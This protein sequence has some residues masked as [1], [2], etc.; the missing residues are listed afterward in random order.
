[1]ICPVCKKSYVSKHSCRIRNCPTCNYVGDV[2]KHKCPTKTV[3][4]ALQVK[5][6][7]WVEQ[8]TAS[9]CT[10][11]ER[12]YPYHKLKSVNWEDQE[13]TIC[14]YCLKHNHH[15]IEHVNNLKALLTRFAS[16]LLCMNCGDK[17][18]D[19]YLD[20]H[21][22]VVEKELH[23]FPSTSY[24]HQI[25]HQLKSRCHP[26]R[27]KFE[28]THR[29]STVPLLT[30]TC[31][32]CGCERRKVAGCFVHVEGVMYCNHCAPVPEETSTIC[33]NCGHRSITCGKRMCPSCCSAQRFIDMKLCTKNAHLMPPS[34]VKAA[35]IQSRVLIQI[36]S[37]L[38]QT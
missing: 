31:A 37:E 34:L 27:I 26:C 20:D 7:E 28:Q 21:L 25:G 2:Y 30:I 33:S 1:M 29:C 10:I 13:H 12:Y 14:R 8:M 19:L 16:S 11:C 9:Q 38:V 24:L 32:T 18:E 23:N 3:E 17:G 4:A 15:I 36:F 5:T 22:F 35:K 6:S